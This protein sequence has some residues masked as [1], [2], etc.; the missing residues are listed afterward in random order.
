[1]SGKST[2]QTQTSSVMKDPWSP[3]QPAPNGILAGS[4][5]AFNSG[6]GSQ[7]YQGPRVAGIGSTTQAGLDYMKADANAGQGAAQATP[8][9]RAR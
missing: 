1:M 2:T 5:N 4:T 8:R 7:I 6:V 9:S 3:A